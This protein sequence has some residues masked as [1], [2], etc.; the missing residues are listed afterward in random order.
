MGGGLFTVSSHP[1][2]TNCIVWDNGGT[3]VILQSGDITVVHCDIAGGPDGSGNIDADPLFVDPDHG[4]YHLHANSPCVNAGTTV[5][6]VTRD[7]E[8]DLRP[9]GVLPDIG[10]DEYVYRS[11]IDGDGLSD[12]FERRVPGEG[13]TNIYLPDSD[14]DGLGD[15]VEDANHNGR[16]LDDGETDPR[17]R[18]TDADGYED[19]IEALVFDTSPLDPDDPETPFM[20]SDRDA[21]PV[22]NDPNDSD[23]D[24]DGDRFKDGY[25]AA[26]YGIPAALGPSY[27][28]PL[29]DVDGNSIWDNADAQRILNF[30]ASVETEGTDISCGD[31][32]RNACIDNADAQA[33][34]N[35]FSGFLSYLPVK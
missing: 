21:L 31:M 27:Y 29:G 25:E 16:H 3:E 1:H 6:G 5:E 20:D 24:S 13:E 14:G 8:W 22:G 7:F 28:P 15:G 18:D 9:F 12:Y 33:S 32:D 10:A 2:L 11:D 35:Y 34:L 4:D 23:P 17:D 26:L 19:G 30:F